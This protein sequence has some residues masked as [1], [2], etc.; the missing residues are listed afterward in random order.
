MCTPV[1]VILLHYGSLHES[2]SFLKVLF[3]KKNHLK[4]YQK[5]HFEKMILTA[6]VSCVYN[7]AMLVHDGKES[8]NLLPIHVG[9]SNQSFHL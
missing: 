5:F 7:S 2:T 9:A 4:L 3:I 6:I 1:I 8:E